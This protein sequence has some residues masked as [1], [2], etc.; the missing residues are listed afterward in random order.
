MEDL[1]EDSGKKTKAECADFSNKTILNI[2]LEIIF[3]Y[4][5]ASLMT[6]N[7]DFRDQS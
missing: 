5:I 2:F 1:N 4:N 7:Y 6:L 3:P